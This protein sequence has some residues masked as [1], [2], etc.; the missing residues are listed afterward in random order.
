MKSIM[1]NFSDCATY[2]LRPD[3]IVLKIKNPGINPKNLK[4]NNLNFFHPK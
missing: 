3:P 2:E 1:L 4:K